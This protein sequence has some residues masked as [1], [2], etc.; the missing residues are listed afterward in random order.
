MS[1]IGVRQQLRLG[2][3]ADRVAAR[4]EVWRRDR[5]L[6]RLLARDARLWSPRPLPELADRLGWVD[7]GE[8]MQ[9]EIPALEAFAEE[10]AGEGV[11][12]VLLLGMGGS[13]LGPEVLE[14]AL[15]AAARSGFP[16]LS[17]LDSTHPDAVR[18]SLATHPPE[19]T[20]YVVSSKSGTTVETL[21][22]YRTFRAVAE[23]LPWPGRRFVAVTDPGT[24]LEALARESDFLGVFA[25]D[26]EVGGRF[27]VL[28]VFGMLPAAITGLDVSSLLA[29]AAAVDLEEALTLGAA[30]GELALGGCDKLTL[31]TDETL[32]AL[33]AWLEQL[34]AESSG[35]G[36]TGIVPVTGEP[37]RQAAQYGPDRLFAAFGVGRE[38]DRDRAAALAAAGRPIAVSM[39]AGPQALGA[40]MM[41][42]EV[43]TAAACA[44]LGVNPFDQPDVERA[45]QLARD[46]LAGARS[47]TAAAASRAVAAAAKDLETMICDWL[48]PAPEGHYVCLQAFLE[49]GA[50]R[51]ALLAEL[52][53]LLGDRGWTTTA[54]FGPRYL[55]STG[56]LH[57]GG[58]EG[59]LFVQL[60][61][62]P[63]DL[64]VAG[65]DETFGRIIASQAAGDA[66]ALAEA[67]RQV[68][69]LELES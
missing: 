40:E 66:A 41:R 55:H 29:G 25:G 5:F 26:R 12:R 11:E 2:P 49:P 6:D 52:R 21:S 22:L 47:S 69:R 62:R 59:G 39:L 38:P 64:A 28:S 46:L 61:D 9:V 18:T 15:G 27:S 19:S 7:L 57:K 35:K 16:R 13:S 44:V 31:E 30:L 63:V 67:G 43:A 10:V 58:P 65:G 34:V 24:P 42:W 37:P 14:S 3:W 20:L 45:K 4:L 48:P 8:R 50:E 1:A 36:G 56:Q 53:G 23:R 60:T 33:P 54:G 68:L 51:R 17:V 32:E